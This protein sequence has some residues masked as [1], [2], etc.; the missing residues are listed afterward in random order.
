MKK[1]IRPIGSNLLIKPF[2]VEEITASGLWVANQQPEMAQ[3]GYVVAVGP[4]K[5][6]EDGVFR[7]IA[8]DD[9]SVVLFR[10]YSGLELTDDAGDKYVLVDEGSILAVEEIEISSQEA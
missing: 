6:R 7:E 5:A 2:P 1:T 10:R 4:G 9:G 8:V 3:R